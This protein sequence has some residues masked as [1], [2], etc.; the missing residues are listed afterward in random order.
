MA[1]ATT[2]QLLLVVAV[3]L[4]CCQLGVGRPSFRPFG[5]FERLRAHSTAF[6][7][8]EGIHQDEFLFNLGNDSLVLKCTSSLVF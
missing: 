3:L 8:N 4:C 7:N 2:H 1:T 6:V 5:G